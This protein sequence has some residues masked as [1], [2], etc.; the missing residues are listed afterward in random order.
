MSMLSCWC[1]RAFQQL[2]LVQSFLPFRLIL[3][4]RE[5]CVQVIERHKVISE[6]RRNAAKMVFG[7][8]VEKLRVGP[9]DQFIVARLGWL[10][11]VE[12]FVFE[13]QLIVL[14][15]IQESSI[16]VERGL[17]TLRE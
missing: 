10:P 11:R 14:N 15:A 1:G 2:E 7:Q 8:L 9:V 13:Q 12:I 17:K 6:F 3:L 5:R 16:L 4:G